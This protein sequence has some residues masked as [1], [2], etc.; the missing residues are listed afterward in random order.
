MLQRQPGKRQNAKPEND[1][2]IRKKCKKARSSFFGG[3]SS[4]EGIHTFG[5]KSK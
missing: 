2:N 4:P 1:K 5:M 3:E